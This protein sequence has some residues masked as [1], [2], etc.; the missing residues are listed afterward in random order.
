MNDDIFDVKLSR[1]ARKNL[2]KVPVY[3]AIKLQ[4]WIEDVGN[5]GLNEVRKIPGYHDEPLHGKRD[6]Q[7][8][9]RLNRS[10]RA[11]YTIKKNKIIRF[12]EIE[13]V[14]KHDY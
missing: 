4:A 8:S 1:G 11:I 9:I 2:K 10:Y 5:H 7:R 3:I 6:G 13:E 12:V 14:N